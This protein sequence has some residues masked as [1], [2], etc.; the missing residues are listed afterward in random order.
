MSN[1]RCRILLLSRSA[2]DFMDEL[3]KAGTAKADRQALIN[4]LAASN[5]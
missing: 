3:P 1:S 2:R 5:A 4:T